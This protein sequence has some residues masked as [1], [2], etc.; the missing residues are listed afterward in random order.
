M[1]EI[2]LQGYMSEAIRRIMAKAYRQLLALI[3]LCVLFL[4]SCKDQPKLNPRGIFD[5]C[6]ASDDTIPA[7]INK[8]DSIT[9]ANLDAFIDDWYK[10]SC[11][12][13]EAYVQEE[14]INDIYVTEFNIDR[15]NAAK[16]YTFKVLPLRVE[17]Y[18]FDKKLN[19]S[20]SRCRANRIK[21]DVISYH[22]QDIWEEDYQIGYITPVLTGED[23]ILYL[24]DGIYDK[25]AS[26]LGGLRIGEK[27][28]DI[29]SPINQQ[30]VD[31]LNERRYFEFHYGHW[32]GYWHLETMP[33]VNYISIFRN[34]V[35]V[36]A[37]ES[38][39]ETN[40]YWYEL[41]SIGYERLSE[42]VGGWIE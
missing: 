9:D 27:N 20:N 18:Y 36:S 32:G 8:Y 37:R 22:F 1:S 11:S 33:I 28:E 31:V 29:F 38:F 39:C 14:T 7:F 2:N 16:K 5:A 24:T 23:S 41:K 10:Y 15:Q 35:V 42:P 4:P 30:H 34:G 40:E 6:H 19:V 13:A 12:V 26:Y 3:T 17:V 25:L 21:K